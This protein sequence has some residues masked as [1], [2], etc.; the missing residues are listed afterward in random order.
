MNEPYG[1]VLSVLDRARRGA[2]PPLIPRQA[3]GTSREARDLPAH[4]REPKGVARFDTPL[5]YGA[6]RTPPRALSFAAR[7]DR[8]PIRSDSFAARTDRL[9]IRS[10]PLAARTDRLQIRSDPFAARADRFEIRS[11]PF[12]ARAD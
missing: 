6:R 1:G 8:L 11:D 3:G 4:G 5:D 9:Q 7:T 12:A 10:D 2:N